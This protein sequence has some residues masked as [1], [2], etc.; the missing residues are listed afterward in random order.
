MRE[1]E[2]QKKQLISLRDEAREREAGERI[3]IQELT[4]KVQPTRD[5]RGA[6]KLINISSSG[7][8]AEIQKLTQK[9][10]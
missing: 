7:E 9:K 2:T 4:K 10:F 5:E 8:G 6:S 1:E 3:E